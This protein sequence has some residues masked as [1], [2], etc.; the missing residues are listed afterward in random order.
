M[1][2]QKSVLQRIIVSHKDIE[3]EYEWMRD[4]PP[5]PL[6]CNSSDRTSAYTSNQQMVQP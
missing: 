1:T 3:K 2:L 6:P 5:P 4:N